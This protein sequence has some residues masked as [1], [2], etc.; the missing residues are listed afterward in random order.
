LP[1]L[2]CTPSIGK[3]GRLAQD[4]LHEALNALTT[5]D[6]GL[7]A[8]VWQRDQELDD[9]HAAVM[10]EIFGCL[11]GD[12]AQAEACSHLQFVAKNLERIGDLSTNI[13]EMVT[14]DATGRRIEKD[15]PRGGA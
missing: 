3:L 6:T 1:A 11:S 13:A 4:L 9:L 15:R 2:S 7:A 8:D 10:E 14:F 12:R 5:R